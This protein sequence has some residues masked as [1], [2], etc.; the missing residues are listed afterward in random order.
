MVVAPRGVYITVS[1]AYITVDKSLLVD[2]RKFVHVRSGGDAAKCHV[3]TFRVGLGLG[4][5]PG[6]VCLG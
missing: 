5:G 1:R 2:L 4:L 6:L 3:D